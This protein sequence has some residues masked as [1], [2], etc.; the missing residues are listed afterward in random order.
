MRNF[1]YTKLLCKEKGL[2][3]LVNHTLVLPRAGDVI[4]PVCGS[5]RVWFASLV[6]HTL[7][8]PCA[9]DAEVGGYG[10]RD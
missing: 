9:G 10:L 2:Y 7:L 8:L 3:S 6:N 1:I 4:H 5:R